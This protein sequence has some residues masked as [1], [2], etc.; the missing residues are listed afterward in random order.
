MKKETFT[1]LLGTA[2]GIAITTILSFFIV[3]IGF[4]V[5]TPRESFK[6]ALGFS[7]GLLAD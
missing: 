7:G 6:D 5:D 1:V 4:P 3:W 2:A